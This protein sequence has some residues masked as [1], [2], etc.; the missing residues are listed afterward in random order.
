MPGPIAH[1]AMFVRRMRFY[2]NRERFER[3][4]A[5]EMRFH[6]DM[7]ARDYEQRGMSAEDARWSA[8]RRFGNSTRLKDDTG[9][10]MAVGWI[11]AAV[12]DA[13]YALR[14]LRQSPASSPR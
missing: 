14:S 11:E 13:R 6:V 4:L 2:F 1:I 12:Q 7:K 10:V 8:Q 9:D 3:E 5:E